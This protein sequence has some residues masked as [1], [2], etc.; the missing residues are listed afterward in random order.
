[1]LGPLLFNIYVNDVKDDT[2]VNSIIIQYADDTFIFC[3]GKTISESKLHLEKVIAKLIL[4]FKKNELNVN[5]IKT[6]FIILGA[7]KRNK[8]EKK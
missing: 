1:M 6:K 2:D 3:S 5:E 8:I 7:P 4:S